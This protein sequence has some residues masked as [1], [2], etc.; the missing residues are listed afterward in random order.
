MSL[1]IYLFW[2]ILT[3]FDTLSHKDMLKPGLWVSLYS[4]HITNIIFKSF[5]YKVKATFQTFLFF[6]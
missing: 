2:Y 1:Y 5:N 6:F 4:L 3:Y